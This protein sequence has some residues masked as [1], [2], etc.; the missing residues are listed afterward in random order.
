MMLFVVEWENCRKGAGR[1]INVRVTS[2]FEG[3]EASL[4]YPTSFILR[5]G[6]QR[7]LV[8]LACPHALS[9]DMPYLLSQQNLYT[10]IL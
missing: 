3:E 6:T 4:P 5:V 7:R 9:I 8:T 10:I 2:K 1:E